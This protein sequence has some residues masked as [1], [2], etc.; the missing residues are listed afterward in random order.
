MIG[1]STNERICSNGKAQSTRTSLGNCSMADPHSSQRDAPIRER[2][3]IALGRVDSYLIQ[4]TAAAMVTT[5][6]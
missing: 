1:H 2:M 4:S 6:R 5:A 3:N